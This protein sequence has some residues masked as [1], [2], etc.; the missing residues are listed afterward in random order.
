M[1][2][3]VHGEVDEFGGDESNGGKHGDAAVLDF[4][5]L[6][7]LD[8]PFVG[9]AEGVEAYGS[10]ETVGVGG[11]GEEGEGFGHF[12]VEGGGGLKERGTWQ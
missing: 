10:D 11:V 6:E 1:H 7:P 9:E 5:F 4:G 8:V 12:G 2:V 3:L